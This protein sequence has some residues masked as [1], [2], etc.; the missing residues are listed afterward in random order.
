MQKTGIRGAV[1]RLHRLGSGSLRR[2]KGAAAI[3]TAG[4]TLLAGVPAAFAGGGGGSSDGGGVMA[5][6]VNWAY[7]D[8]N[9]GAFGSSGD[10]NSING[11]FASMGVIMLP[12]GI[13]HA[14]EALA[15][16][17]NNCLT[18][19]NQAHP[20][21][22]GQGQCRIVGVGAMTGPNK[23]FSGEAHHLKSDWLQ[24]WALGPGPWKWNIQQSRSYIQH[25][26]YFPRSAWCFCGYDCRSVYE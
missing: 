23:Q 24:A 2:L 21:Q 13:A 15:E 4:A 22:A 20:D 19:F 16:A 10:F 7:R 12:D 26:R 6:Q 14:Q 11:A 25:G 9:G 8:A 3:V 1:E 5:T 18:S 17:S